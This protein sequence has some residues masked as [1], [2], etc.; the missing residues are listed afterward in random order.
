M[1]LPH[2]SI[3]VEERTEVYEWLEPL[4]LCNCAV[5]CESEGECESDCSMT[6][7]ECVSL[8]M[9]GVLS[10]YEHPE[11]DIKSLNGIDS[12]VTTIYAEF[13][14]PFYKI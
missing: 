12:F 13:F 8:K 1:P 7:C 9:S 6:K 10:W 2:P 4:T 5:S 11:Q 14:L 3:V